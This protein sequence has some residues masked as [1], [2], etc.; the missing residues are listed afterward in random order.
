MDYVHYTDS[1]YIKSL[2]N[3]R[4]IA[5]ENEDWDEYE[6]ADKS[7]K[8]HEQLA[9][10]SPFG[11]YDFYATAYRRL[12]AKGINPSPEDLHEE[13]ARVRVEL[14]EYV[15]EERSAPPRYEGYY[16]DGYSPQEKLD[17]RLRLQ[18]AG[19]QNPTSGH[20]RQELARTAKRAA[21]SKGYT[22]RAHH[23]RMR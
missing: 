5:R 12:A 4:K 2:E 21:Q 8:Y 10:L 20:I 23:P 7:L 17:A 16:P 13:A 9:D 3:R 6:K 22:S 18:A 14:K 15:A 1:D 19:L 11:G